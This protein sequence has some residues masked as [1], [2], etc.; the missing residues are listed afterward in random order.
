MIIVNGLQLL[1]I[2]TKHSIL[3]VA[4]ALDPPLMYLIFEGIIISNNCR[5]IFD[6]INVFNLKYGCFE[7]NILYPPLP[8]TFSLCCV[9][10]CCIV[11]VPSYS[12]YFLSLVPCSNY[13][14]I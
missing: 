6:V 10:S 4:A 9:V 5:F 8:I 3:D 12:I 11:S 1:T 13:S 7:E 14:T 2:I